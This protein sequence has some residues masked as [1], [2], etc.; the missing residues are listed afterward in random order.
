[1]NNF[2]VKEE[3]VIGREP[4]EGRAQGE[5]LRGLVISSA[6]SSITRI[7]IPLVR[8]LQSVFWSS[9]KHVREHQRQLEQNT[10]IQLSDDEYLPSPILFPPVRA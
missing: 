1:M 7:F 3:E 8:K 9:H 5:R 4:P 6:S 10:T 2:E